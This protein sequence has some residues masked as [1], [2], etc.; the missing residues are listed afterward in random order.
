MPENEREALTGRQLVDRGLHRHAVDDLVGD[1]AD[2]RPPGAE[3]VPP[4]APRDPHRHDVGPARRSV[5]AADP[6]P[7]CVRPGERLLRGILGEQRVAERHREAPE[8]RRVV[9]GEER[10][11]RS[12]A[13][14]HLLI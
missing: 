7:S 5:H 4:P 1:V 9:L 10:L 12:V 8:H 14:A 13:A 3:H 6:L 11:E 2:R